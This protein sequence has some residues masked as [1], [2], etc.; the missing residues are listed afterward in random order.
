[1]GQFDADH[2]QP[3]APLFP[4]ERNCS[5][6]SSWRATAD[7]FRRSLAQDAAEYLPSWRQARPHVL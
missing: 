1:M 2:T 4:S 3:G 6:G 7:V 5:D